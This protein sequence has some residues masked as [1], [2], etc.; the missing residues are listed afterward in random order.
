MKVAGVVGRHGQ[1]RPRGAQIGASISAQSAPV[2]SRD[3]LVNAALALEAKLGDTEVPR[4]PNWGGFV[5]KPARFE[6][7]QGRS[8]RLH[9]RV[10]Y[11]KRGTSW[12]ISRLAP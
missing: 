11:E 4:P 2:P 7:W 12:I 5:L 3:A 9:D 1:A 8:D 6:F 10:A